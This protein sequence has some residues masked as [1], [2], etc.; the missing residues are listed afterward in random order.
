MAQR[1]ATY[2][3]ASTAVGPIDAWPQSLR[4]AMGLMLESRFAMCLCWGPELTLFY[5]DAYAPHLGAK[6]T[7]ALG[8]P[9]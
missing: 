8:Q 7:R 4:T 3:W 6:E 9:L 2:D 1:I 5:N